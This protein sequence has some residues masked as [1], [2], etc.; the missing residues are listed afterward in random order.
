MSRAGHVAATST[1]VQRPAN[2][3]STGNYQRQRINVYVAPA[4]R[5]QLDA[6]SAEW[7]VPLVEAVRRVLGSGLANIMHADSNPS[8][9]FPLCASP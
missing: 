5:H 4:Y 6:L 7:G 1:H 2:H 8:P 3:V 9:V